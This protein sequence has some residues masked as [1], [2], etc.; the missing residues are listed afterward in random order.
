MVPSPPP[1]PPSNPAAG[2]K[3]PPPPP[4]PPTPG[5]AQ[6]SPPP[7]TPPV[8]A[9]ISTTESKSR[10]AHANLSRA[11]AQGDPA[12]ESEPLGRDQD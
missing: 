11:N 5:F 12:I 1:P 6:P 10:S 4:A 9:Q 3:P 8:R 2:V 7:P